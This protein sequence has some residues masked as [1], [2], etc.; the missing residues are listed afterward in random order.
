LSQTSL[1]YHVW[2]AADCTQ[3]FQPCHCS[4]YGYGRWKLV[5]GY[6]RKG[7]GER[8]EHEWA[9]KWSRAH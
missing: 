3:D 6:R 5:T 1:P 8:G 9:C 2:S 7:V 4:A